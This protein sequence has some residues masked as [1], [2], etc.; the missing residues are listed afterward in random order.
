MHIK[1]LKVRLP[2]VFSADQHQNT[3]ISSS[4]V[5]RLINTLWIKIVTSTGE[6][7]YKLE[8]NSRTFQYYW[9]AFPP[10]IV[11]KFVGYDP[12]S[13]PYMTLTG[14]GGSHTMGAE[15]NFDIPDEARF[16]SE[17][18]SILGVLTK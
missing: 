7:P 4:S 15:L 8:L 5:V 17:G 9:D 2:I 18:G 6:I 3:V 13:L 10:E 16:L 11:P 12:I 14:E 1:S